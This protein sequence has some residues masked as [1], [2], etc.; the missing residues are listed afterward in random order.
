MAVDTVLRMNV[1]DRQPA[2][3]LNPTAM[4][5][6]CLQPKAFFTFFALLIIQAMRVD[7]QQNL[8]SD[9]PTYR[10]VRNHP[11]ATPANAVGFRGG[12]AMLIDPSG[13]LIERI[14]VPLPG[15]HQQSPRPTGHPDD[16]E[17][18]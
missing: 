10:A 7:L 18:C 17:R 11:D 13:V 16:A 9:D 8:N 3:L 2:G 5:S 15:G 1:W 12:V 6:S 14:N 4:I